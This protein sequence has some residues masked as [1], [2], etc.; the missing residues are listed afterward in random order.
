MKKI[1]SL[2]AVVALFTGCASGPKF[3][4]VKS[5]IPPVAQDHG[6]IYFYRN[7][8]A[9]AAVQP[10]VRLNDQEV[11]RATSKGF[12]YVDRTPGSYEVKTITEVTR[13]LSLNL[14]QGQTRYVRL[15]IAMGFFVGHVYPELVE[16]A[17]G[18]KEIQ[19]CSYTGGK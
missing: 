10:A 18:E 5:T 13:R 1:L 6:R 19:N 7:S 2:V 9:G 16:N 15:N 11:G 14:D 4:Q 12:F 3:S 17:I 8:V